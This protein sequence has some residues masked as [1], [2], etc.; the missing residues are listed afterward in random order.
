MAKAKMIH[1]TTQQEVVAHTQSNICLLACGEHIQP[2]TP[3][4]DN[5]LSTPPFGTVFPNIS[6]TEECQK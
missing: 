3:F 1:V 5:T 2:V 4:H 6:S